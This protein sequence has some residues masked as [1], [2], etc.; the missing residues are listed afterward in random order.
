MLYADGVPLYKKPDPAR[1]PM[2][3]EYKNEKNLRTVGTICYTP[4]EIAHN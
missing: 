4:I 2:L 1:D 3:V